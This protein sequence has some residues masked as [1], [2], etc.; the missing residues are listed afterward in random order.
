MP[1]SRRRRRL[2]RPTS[3]WID[4]EADALEVEAD[5][6][7]GGESLR[8]ELAAALADGRPFP[9]QITPAPEALETPFASE[10]RSSDETP[11]AAASADEE[12]L[13]R[14]V[15]P[16][17]PMPPAGSPLPAVGAPPMAELTQAES[18]DGDRTV[19]SE[20]PSPAMLAALRPPLPLTRQRRRCHSRAGR[21]AVAGACR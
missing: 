20:P 9:E 21:A 11:F 14:V 17:P 7:V 19:I 2:P 6:D 1:S 5:N 12:F 13:R 16:P 8:P 18:D 3:W 15:L 10:T 4:A